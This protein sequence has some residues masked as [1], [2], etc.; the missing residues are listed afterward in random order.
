[1]DI[2]EVE[3]MPIPLKTGA[4]SKPGRVYPVG[5]KDREVIDKTFD[6]LHDQG[7]MTWSTMPT[8][9]SYPVFVVWK[10]TA[11]GRKGRVVVDIREL[12]KIAENDTYPL[13]LQ[14]EII[15]L[16]LGYAFLSTIDAVGWFHQF[17][18]QHQG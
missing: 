16:L 15:A 10:D 13:P 4:V 1:M 6:K 5:Q 3:W 17:Q 8:P 18:V 11:D 2:P 12:N 7:K 14:S 9:F